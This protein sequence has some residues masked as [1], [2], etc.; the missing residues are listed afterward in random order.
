M[1]RF[2]LVSYLMVVPNPPLPPAPYLKQAKL[3]HLTPTQV[4]LMQKTQAEYALKL[5]AQRK[6]LVDLSLQYHDAMWATLTPEQ[7]KLAL[8]HKIH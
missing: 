7:Q 5:A 2:L 4:D 8:K 1:L 3:L 6:V